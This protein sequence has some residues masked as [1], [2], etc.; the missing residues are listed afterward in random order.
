MAR[1]TEEPEAGSMRAN[2]VLFH[3]LTMGAGPLLLCLH[4]FPDHA[5]SFRSQLNYFSAL[6][7]RVVAPFMR[8][9]AP[10][11]TPEDA[12]FFIADLAHDVVKL[13]K[14]LGATRAT[15]LGHDWGAHAAYGAAV[16]A[17]DL[18]DHIV[19]LA[20]PYGGG[21]RSAL[22]TS[23]EQ[24]RRSW[25]IF[26]FQSRLAEAAIAHD[27]YAL[28]RQLWEDWS[29]GW[30]PSPD[31]MAEL[32]QSLAAPGVADAALSYY[33]CAFGPATPANANAALQRRIGTEPIHVPCLNLHGERDGCI[34]HSVGQ[35]MA[36][37][38]P[39][40]LERHVMPELG[41]FLHLEAPDKVNAMIASYLKGAAARK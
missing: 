10:T 28:V 39:H 35:N 17:P 15:L 34:G 11:E 38:F 37:Y 8:G 20:A 12:T 7:Y 21:F 18:F 36:E 27:D 5:Y 1:A 33:R 2:N 13:V 30:K 25:Y 6:G 31:A 9:Y 41:H 16:L 23:A 32:V 14:S 19:T 4:G 22:V 40:G 24:Q 29:P 3:Y 26:F